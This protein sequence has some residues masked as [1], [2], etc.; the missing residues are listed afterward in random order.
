MKRSILVLLLLLT[1]ACTVGPDY[2]PPVVEAPPA[3]HH[4]EDSPSE[5]P[6]TSDSAED[7]ETGW[8]KVLGD[9]V[10]NQLVLDAVTHNHDLEQATARVREAQ[11]GRR[12]SAARGLP[13]VGASAE[14]RLFEGSENAPGPN[15]ALAE[16]GL[17]DLEDDAYFLGLSASWEIDLFGGI[18]RSVEAA[19]AR[20][21][22]AEEGRRAVLLGVIAEV[23]RTY[24]ELRGTQRRLELAEKNVELQQG[25]YEVVQT[26]ARVGLVS[27]LDERRAAAQLEGTRS[28]VPPLRAT[29]RMAAHRLAVLTGRSPAELLDT[30][31][32]VRPLSDP[33]DLVPVGL[34]SELL[35]RRPDVR[36]AERQLAAATADVGVRTADLYPRFSLTG[37]AGLDSSSFADL[38]A[39][40]SRTWNLAAGLTAPI[41]Q[42]GRIRAGIEAA[43]ARTDAALAAYHQAVL[44]ALEDVE[45]ALV[46]Y[47][48]EELRRRTLTEAAQASGRATELARILYDKGL[49]DYLTVLDA[50]RNLTEVEDRL[51]QSETGVVLRLVGL[52]AA[53]G[54]G[55]EEFTP[56]TPTPGSASKSESPSST[57]SGLPARAASE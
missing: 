49:E 45:N 48:E 22:V 51:A 11:A 42:G 32:E 34:P 28:R 39:G 26:R 36:L 38:F 4:A 57:S 52:Y 8:W 33:P 53:L 24:T 31:L 19:E 12:A 13:Q 10:L 41:F 55:W 35:A 3:F 44:S 16:A 37:A 21:A 6:S 9:D 14:G 2:V 15:G 7:V 27:E 18:R 56:R 29:V 43:E 47:A 23:A 20:I 54:G 46:N 30:L 50:E 5:E 25:T 17:A 1:S 40:A